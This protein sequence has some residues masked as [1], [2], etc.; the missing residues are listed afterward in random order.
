MSNA[1]GMTSHDFR[2]YLDPPVERAGS[3]SGT[4]LPWKLRLIFGL[5]G[6]LLLAGAFAA[7]EFGEVAQ[8]AMARV[9]PWLVVIA[10]V[11][12]AFAILE[13]ITAQIWMALIIGA[14]AVAVTFLVVGRVSTY[15]SQ[16]QSVFVVDR[17]SGE[18]AL[19]TAQGCKV[20]PREG[21]FLTTPALSLPSLKRQPA[22]HP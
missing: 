15:P 22:Q 7:W 8:G 10:F 4:I 3:V 2:Q 5:A 14:F 17:F 1:S 18:V 11:L 13:T 6:V 9:V 20:L 21:V 12:G 19:C 16:G